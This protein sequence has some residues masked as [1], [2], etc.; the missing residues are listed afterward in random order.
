MWGRN[1]S[2]RWAI[3]WALK[4]GAPGHM[5]MEGGFACLGPHHANAV[6]TAMDAALC[7][8]AFQHTQGVNT[9]EKGVSPCIRH[10]TSPMRSWS[11]CSMWTCCRLE[12]VMLWQ[13]P[14]SIGMM[15]GAGTLDASPTIPATTR[16]NPVRSP[17]GVRPSGWSYTQAHQL[18]S[19]TGCIAPQDHNPTGPESLCIVHGQLQKVILLC[20]F[21][22]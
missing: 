2:S 10:C 17:L 14:A 12:R 20:I 8:T 1:C 21:F 16:G 11:G 18:C 6:V 5:A 4:S 9:C 3:Y 13:D 22:M 15:T 19:A 7:S